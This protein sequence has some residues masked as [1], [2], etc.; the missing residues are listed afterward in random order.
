[1]KKNLWLRKL[2]R[3]PQLFARFELDHVAGLDLDGR[4]GLGI[5]AGSG[6]APDFLECA[7]SHQSDFSVF[8]LQ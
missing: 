7:K 3:F 2:N 5:S 4:T 1:L 8:F 6:L